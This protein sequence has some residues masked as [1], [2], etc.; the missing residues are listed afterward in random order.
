MEKAMPQSYTSLIYHI[1]FSTKDRRP[2]LPAALHPRV[3]AYIGGILRQERGALLE[4]GG[5]ENHVHLLAA[6]SKEQ[7]LSDAVRVI[8]SNSSGWLHREVGRPEFG[9]QDG[10]GGFTVDSGDTAELV[11][12]IRNQ[13]EHHRRVTFEEEFIGLLKRH[14]VSYDE[15]YLWL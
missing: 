2:M 3:F 5:T 12:Y 14:R 11:S 8:K 13:E 7:A 6:V 9:W 1:V 4:V 15:R 10:Y